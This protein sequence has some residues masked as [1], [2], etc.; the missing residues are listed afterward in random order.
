VPLRKE[1]KVSSTYNTEST[2]ENNNTATDLSAFPTPKKA[3]AQK[4]L[5]VL[6]VEQQHQVLQVLTV[7]MSKSIIK[8]KLGYLSCLV[9]SALTGSFTEIKPKFVLY[10]AK[11]RERKKPLPVDNIAHFAALKQKYGDN[12]VIETNHCHNNPSW[13]QIKRNLTGIR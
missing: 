1:P 4:I 8:N 7:M 6:T 5:A 10:P 11:Q 12:G 13:Q 9:N 2:S 3:G